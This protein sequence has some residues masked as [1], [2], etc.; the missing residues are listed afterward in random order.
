MAD[1]AEILARAR[2]KGANVVVRDGSL[3]VV[4]A[5]RLGPGA[6]EFIAANRA[7]ILVLLQG[8]DEDAEERAALIEFEGRTPREWA[9][10]FA[11]ILARQRPA[12][13]TDLDWSWFVSRCAQMVE[14]V[15]P[16][17][18]AAA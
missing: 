9:E 8:E 15:P 14:E 3:V 13:V 12:G 10:Q 2:S 1:P 4:N 11:D 17:Y 6:A 16:P 18:G 7:A 5:Y